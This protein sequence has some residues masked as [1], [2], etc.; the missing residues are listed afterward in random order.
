V[1]RRRT[2]GIRFLV[3]LATS[4]VLCCIASTEVP[5]ILSLSDN[6]ANDFVVVKAEPLPSLVLRDAYTL[7]LDAMN[8]KAD[9]STTRKPPS[10][11][12]DKVKP[13]SSDLLVLY[14]T[15]RT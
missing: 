10:P 2:I 15:L 5:E 9:R 7:R 8:R 1:H 4:L 14:S 13:S 12:V 11:L 3:F 6:A